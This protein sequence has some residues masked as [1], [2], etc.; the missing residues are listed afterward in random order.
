MFKYV[1]HEELYNFSTN[2]KYSAYCNET[3]SQDI[4]NLINND[5]LKYDVYDKIKKV[6]GLHYNKVYFYNY[7]LS[8]V[9]CPDIVLCPII[10][11]AASDFGFY[12]IAVG[13]MER[14]KFGTTYQDTK[15]LFSA[16]YDQIYRAIV[17]DEFFNNLSDEVD[18]L[19]I[20]AV[21][22]NV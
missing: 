6:C 15:V 12:N 20:K 17:E 21:L 3:K 2:I 22:N 5:M 13:R 18:N 4:I 7:K 8:F 19:I 14:G 10:L 9:R 11:Y 16:F 1:S